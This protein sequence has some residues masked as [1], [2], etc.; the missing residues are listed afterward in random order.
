[1]GCCLKRRMRMKNRTNL[2]AAAVCT[3][4]IG[5]L[6]AAPTA[7]AAETKGPVT[8]DLGVL[9]IPKGAP[10][11]I[12]GYWVMSGADSALGSDEKRGVEIAIKDQGG[13][14]VGHPVKLSVE[15]DGCNAEGGQTAATKLAANPQTAIVLGPACSSA[16]TPG[17]PILWQQGVVDI[18]TACTAP[19]LTAA[20][21]KPEY[22]GFA[23]TVFSDS[24]Q[25]KADATYVHNVLKAQSVVTVHDG[26][27]YAQQLQQVMADNFKQLGGKVLSQEA[28]APSD[29]D[30]HPLL[31]RIASE[32]P[33]LVYFPVFTAAAAQI[34]RQAKETPGLEKTALMGGGS[35]LSAD[36]I[37][38][39]GPAVVGF[40]I[41]YPDLSPAAMGKNYPKFVADYKKAYGEAP[42]SGYHANAY[43]GA[44]LTIKAIEKVA[45]S[46]S[47]GNLYIG[48]K[49]L[50]DAVFSIKFD[51]IS[52]P[53]ACDQYG[54][55]SQFKP[56]VLEF[57]SADPKTFAIR[58]NPKR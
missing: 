52:G 32:K 58:T 49:A 3:G 11:Q 20:T 53:I 47:A 21:R 40:R 5:S 45:K 54:E 33:D 57:T 2:F 50:R 34:L 4:L 39:A 18:C 28:I 36:F 25:G 43:D 46:D 14:L 24:E 42:I 41:G 55:C 38:A 37:E 26:S 1:M 7:S 31:T 15:D 56:S 48:K 13:T 6:F 17:A 12:G 19:A 10:I 44:M 35:L 29:V 8:D 30:M 16:A 23:R 51:G 9:M 27:P 22:A